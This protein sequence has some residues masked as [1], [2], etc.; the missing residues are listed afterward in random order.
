MANLW[1]QFKELLPSDTLQVGEVIQIDGDR[2]KLQLPSGEFIW[3]S[4]NSVV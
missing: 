1:S 3:V 4:G 2:S